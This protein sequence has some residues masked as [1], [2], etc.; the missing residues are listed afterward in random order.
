[1]KESVGCH[2]Q[3]VAQGPWFF[4]SGNFR[5]VKSEYICCV[6]IDTVDY[7]SVG[8]Q[9]C[10]PK[11]QLQDVLSIPNI[12][13]LLSCSVRT[14]TPVLPKWSHHH[15]RSISTSFILIKVS[16]IPG[17]NLSQGS[18]KHTEVLHR[19]I[20]PCQKWTRALGCLCWKPFHGWLGSQQHQGI[21]KPRKFSINIC[22]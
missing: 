10:I 7:D 18:T 16:Q 3:M 4:V 5:W 1:M 19:W 8:N 12:P 14:F 9:I 20:C 15:S 22:R 13:S 6:R 2:T 17:W 11:P 21:G